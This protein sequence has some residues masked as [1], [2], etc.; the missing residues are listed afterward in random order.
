MSESEP[1]H[2]HEPEAPPP[3]EVVDPNAAVIQ[4]EEIASESPVWT[5][6][7]EP[8]ALRFRGPEG[9]GKE[10]VV[11]K[12]ALREKTQLLNGLLMRRVMTARL[13]DPKKLTGFRFEPEAWFALTEWYG[14]PNQA[15]LR[16]ALSTR[17][18]TALTIGIVLLFSAFMNDYIRGTAAQTMY[19]FLGGWLVG[20]WI[21]SKAL[22]TRWWFLADSGV[23]VVFAAGLGL[24]LEQGDWIGIALTVGCLMLVWGGL[25]KYALFKRVKRDGDALA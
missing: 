4:A 5:L 16:K 9:S 20:V 10:F 19:L 14:Y 3:G 25:K 17:M 15:D 7:L 12:D 18:A 13:E 1:G 23:Y 24:G 2:E 6:A 21:L 8:D 11:A 22:P